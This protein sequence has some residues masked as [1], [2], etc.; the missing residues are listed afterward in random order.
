MNSLR[1]LI[2][3]VSFGTAIACSDLE[4]RYFK[5]Q[6][7]NVTAEQVAQKYGT[8]H[9]VLEDDSGNTVW[10]YFER[11]SATASY[12]GTAKGGICRAYRLSFDE[13]NILRDWM[14]GE[15]QN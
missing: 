13:Q 5:D 8:P 9:K 10:T 4:S 12:A 15:C 11:G 14:Q 7:N 2:F 6:V 3:I 1:L